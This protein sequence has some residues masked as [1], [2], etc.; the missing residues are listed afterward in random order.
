[1]SLAYV[2]AFVPILAM[3]LIGICK[4]ELFSNAS[5]LKFL[6]KGMLFIIVFSVVIL[7]N[8]LNVDRYSYNTKFLKGMSD[9]SKDRAIDIDS[10]FLL[11]RDEFY[12]EQYYTFNCNEWLLT[13][14]ESFYYP[15]RYYD[16]LGN[17][18]KSWCGLQLDSR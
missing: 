1:M 7:A 12:R 9:V 13:V 10:K 18:N 3:G 2:H 5:L 4:T 15:Q 16:T 17:F 6:S 8:N 14:N 11:V